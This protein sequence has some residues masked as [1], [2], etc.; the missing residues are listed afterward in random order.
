MIVRTHYAYK[1]STFEYPRWVMVTIVLISLSLVILAFYFDL[2]AVSHIEMEFDY[3]NETVY[4][5]GPSSKQPGL[6]LAA[7]IINCAMSTTAVILF[8]KPLITMINHRP[9]QG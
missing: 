6:K 4:F 8:V 5:C 2:T 1:G 3:F 7:F 9:T